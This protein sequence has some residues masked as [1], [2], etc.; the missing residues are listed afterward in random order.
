MALGV[1]EY[2]DALSAA[3]ALAARIAQQ[4]PLPVRLAKVLLRSGAD[5]SLDA[6]LDLE[7]SMGAMVFTTADAR[8]GIDAFVQKRRP[9]FKGA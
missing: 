9:D 4:A 1:G 6:A 8:E 7:Q 3:S 5:A 2:P